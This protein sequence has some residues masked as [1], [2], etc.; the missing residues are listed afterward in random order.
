MSRRGL[1]WFPKEKWAPV[2]RL[3]A[4]SGAAPGLTLLR[5]RW[6]SWRPCCKIIPPPCRVDKARASLHQGLDTPGTLCRGCEGA[7]VYCRCSALAW[8]HPDAAAARRATA[9]LLARSAILHRGTANS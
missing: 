5:N 6:G 8:M 2:L 7:G 9:R 1:G 4:S 3:A